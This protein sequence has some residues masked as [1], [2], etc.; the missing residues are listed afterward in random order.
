M[1]DTVHTRALFE[2]TPKRLHSLAGLKNQSHAQDFDT[3][4]NVK[5]RVRKHVSHIGIIEYI[6]KKQSL[7][8]RYS[9]CWIDGCVHGF[10][11]FYEF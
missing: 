7:P 10:F 3:L 6:L 1:Y 9:Q 4:S 8:C 2:I 5:L 11:F